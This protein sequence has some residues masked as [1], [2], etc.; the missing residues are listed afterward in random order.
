MD[1]MVVWTTAQAPVAPHYPKAGRGRRPRQLGTM[2]RIYLRQQCLSR[3]DL[4]AEAMLDDS[5]SMRR[6]ARINLLSDTV[7][8]ET[9]TCRICFSLVALS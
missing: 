7:P 1:Q 2:L 5:A 6:F 9:T 3:S 4:K 8:D